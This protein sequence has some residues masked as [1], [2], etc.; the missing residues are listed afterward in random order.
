M[1]D[2]ATACC[3]CGASAPNVNTNYTL[4]SQTGWRLSRA[5]NVGGTI[6]MEWRCPACWAKRKPGAPRTA[7]SLRPTRY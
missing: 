4:I 2:H 5:P 7:R 6:V 3:E 1:S